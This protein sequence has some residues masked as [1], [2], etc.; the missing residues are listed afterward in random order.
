MK[1]NEYGEKLRRIFAEEKTTLA[2]DLENENFNGMI[3]YDDDVETM[4]DV[5][6]Y[7]I[8]RYCYDVFDV[9]NEWIDDGYKTVF[10]YDITN[11]ITELRK[12][13]D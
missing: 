9:S 13:F 3:F 11:V 4:N 10:G 8:E 1:L 5:I 2:Q 12:C 6:G 7:M